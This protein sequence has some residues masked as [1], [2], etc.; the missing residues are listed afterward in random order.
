L[1]DKVVVARLHRRFVS[2]LICIVIPVLYFRSCA[3]VATPDDACSAVKKFAFGLLILLALLVA[4]VLVVPGQLDWTPYRARIAQEIGGLTGRAVTID[5]P[6]SFEMLPM[7][8]LVAGD[9]RVERNGAVRSRAAVAHVGAGPAA[10]SAVAPRVVTL[11]GGT[12]VAETR[13]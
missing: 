4:A 7:P 13:P 5:G 12:R 6:V 8:R 2:I 11:P 1:A 3:G 9:V 10:P